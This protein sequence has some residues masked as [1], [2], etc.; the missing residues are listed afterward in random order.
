MCRSFFF[1]GGKEVIKVIRATFLFKRKKKGVSN[2][3]KATTQKKD[4]EQ[5]YLFY[6]ALYFALLTLLIQKDGYSQ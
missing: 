3:T 5:V 4:V 1:E 6:S 2:F